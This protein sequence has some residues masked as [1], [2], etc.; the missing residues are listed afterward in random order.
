MFWLWTQEIW[1]ARSA[2][3]D[4]GGL[5]S[6]SVSTVVEDFLA[7]DAAAKAV[8]ASFKLGTS[9][10]TLGPKED[11]AWFDKVLPR[12]WTLCEP[13]WLFN[14]LNVLNLLGFLHPSCRT[15]IDEDLGNAGVESAYAQVTNRSSEGGKWVIPWSEE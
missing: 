10:W 15:S 7:A 12:D 4:I 3:G 2:T 14:H 6:S 5:S 11:R 13:A 9:G 1:N 8:N